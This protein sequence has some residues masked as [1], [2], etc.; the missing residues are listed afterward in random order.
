VV[1]GV[2]SNVFPTDAAILDTIAV[3]RD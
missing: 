2:T 1:D 3:A